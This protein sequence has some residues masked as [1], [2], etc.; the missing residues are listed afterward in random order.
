MTVKMTVLVT[1][2]MT[3]IAQKRVL[4][5]GFGRP[6]FWRHFERDATWARPSWRSG[7]AS[8][9]RRRGETSPV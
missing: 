1:V 4:D 3:V 7:G 2:I 6:G 8:V 5:P 9:K